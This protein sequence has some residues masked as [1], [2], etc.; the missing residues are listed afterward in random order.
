MKVIL[1]RTFM[2]RGM[3]ALFALAML[4]AVAGCGGKG[5]AG[6][7]ADSG[8]PID[9]SIPPSLGEVKDLSFPEYEEMAL[10]NG[11]ELL[12]VE[13][14]EQP[15]VSI[16][17]TLKAGNVL[18][19][20]EKIGLASLTAELLNK[21]TPGRTADEIAEEIEFLGGSLSAS[22]DDDVTTISVSV[23]SEYVD[24]AMELLA[25]VTLNATFPED[26]LETAR[27]RFIS[28][29]QIEL[30]QPEA[31]AER[32]F[33]RIIYGDH[34]YAKAPT[35]KSLSAITREDLVAFRDK[36]FVSNNAILAVAG[37]IKASK[38]EELVNTYFGHWAPGTP[39]EPI[40]WDPPERAKQV[41]YLFDKP[42]A[43]QSNFRVGYPTYKPGNPDIYGVRLMNRVLGESSA[44]RLFEVLRQD[45]G[46][47]YGA[48]SRFSNPIDMGYFRQW[49]AV[50]TEVTD[51]AFVELMAQFNRIRDEVVP[52]DELADAKAYVTGNFPLTIETPTQ[53][54]GQVMFVKLRGYGKDYLDTYRSRVAA[55]DAMT[56]QAMAR[57]Y[58][59]PE[60]MA[61]VIVGNAKEIKEKLEAVA[62]EV[63][64][65]DLEGNPISEDALEVAAVSY[66]YALERLGSEEGKYKMTYQGMDLGIV[67]NK[68]MKAK[69]RGK[70]V[71]VVSGECSGMLTFNSSLTFSADFK[72]VSRT[73]NMTSPMPMTV[74]LSYDDGK[75]NGNAELPQQDP[76]TID[77]E[78]VEGTLDSEMLELA[79]R[80][81][82]LEEGASY[83]F[84]VYDV[85]SGGLLNAKSE[86]LGVESVTVPAGTFDAYKVEVNQG[87]QR[88]HL[89]LE[90]AANHRLIKADYLDQ[91]MTMELTE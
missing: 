91:G 84:P 88:A 36:N 69:R 18:D 19:P 86:V 13:H 66:D 49:M 23:L 45:K 75:V 50:R 7:A 11:L 22:S 63:E 37:D 9:R 72:P 41:V 57:K 74:D 44:S 52:A 4:F 58:V 12:V 73:F 38:F 46:W 77:E 10:D 89:F 40:Y 6:S 28:A 56:V 80:L 59:R 3:A 2:L 83:V 43:V 16:R 68:L 55:V 35:E 82:D 90:V 8:E 20:E 85:Q 61:V 42:G 76:K 32:H 27:K 33:N 30:S 47:T 65:Y 29:L 54:L 81:L 1:E 70:E 53:V 71:Y 79:I 51:S 78:L 5:A 39:D 34:P 21:G 48:Y 15:L 67:T 87:G 24:E 26:E 31:M 25:D 14:H 64:L 62:P 17:V 60:E